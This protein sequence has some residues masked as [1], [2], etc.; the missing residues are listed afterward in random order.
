MSESPLRSRGISLNNDPVE[1][2]S[3]RSAVRLWT[4]LFPRELLL[5]SCMGRLYLKDLMWVLECCEFGSG[6]LG[7]LS[8]RVCVCV[9][10]YV[11]VCV[12]VCVYM[13]VCVCV[14]ENV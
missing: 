5:L 14:C 3:I 8:V 7:G 12:C 9:C 13:C 2:G 10:V 11:C 6:A 1:T 4:G